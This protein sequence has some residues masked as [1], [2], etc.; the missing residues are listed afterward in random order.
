MGQC[1]ALDYARKL[2]H[3]ELFRQTTKKGGKK[4]LE[5]QYKDKKTGELKPFNPL[6]TIDEDKVTF[7]EQFDGINVIVT[8]ETQMSDEEIIGYYGQLYKIEDCFKVTKTEFNAK[9]IYVRLE[10]HIEAH[11]LTC[12]LALV[13]IRVLQHKTNWVY[14]AGRIIEAMN[15][16]Q[17]F[18]LAT[19]FYKVTANEDLKSIFKLLQ[20]DFDKDIVRYETLN[21]FNN[22]WCT[23]KK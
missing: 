6:I 13:L 9:P 7:D 22:F 17:A 8:S 2:T 5:I 23:T 10:E 20:I 15:S 1:S 4:Y 21:Q 16:A 12:F 11:F 18:E 14:S 19:G 3:P